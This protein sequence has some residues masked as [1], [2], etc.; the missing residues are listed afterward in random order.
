MNISKTLVAVAVLSVFAASAHAE[1]QVTIFGTADAGYRWSGKNVNP[2]IGDQ[3]RIDSGTSIPSRLGFQGGE[4]LGNG[5]RA[6]FVLEAAVDVTGGGQ[7]LGGGGFSRQAFVAL[8]GPL[9]KVAV[10]RQYTPGY[11][12]TSEVDPFGSVTTGQYNNVYLTEY[13]WD[14]QLTY[15]SPELDG[16]SFSLAYT[17]NGYGQESVGNKGTGAVGDVEG[18]SF[19]P[20]YR[21]GPLLVG[22]HLQQLSSS[23]NGLDSSGKALATAYDGQKVRVFDLGGTYDL[24]IVKLAA[25]YGTRRAD[26]ADFSPD[27]GASAGKDTRQWL[28]GATLPVGER[29]KILASYVHRQTALAS[30][31]GTAR[32]GQ[33]A[34]GYE[35]AL[36][37]RTALYAVL[38]STNNNAVGRDAGFISSVG[39]GYNAGDGYQRSFVSGIR[40]SF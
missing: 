3:S 11:L 8:G 21:K 34:A 39:A 22:A 18:I 33:W 36:S 24:G 4:N 2:T 19:V 15:F 38:A 28:L 29:G 16:A 1:D 10:G 25:A 13:R 6:S 17:L 30:G 5:L 9:G 35:Y 14:N 23:T 12:L 32:A 20:Q 27:T 26:R 37:R 31:S 40:H 7:L